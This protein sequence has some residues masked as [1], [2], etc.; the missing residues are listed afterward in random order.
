MAKIRVEEHK[1]IAKL[2]RQISIRKT[3][4]LRTGVH[5]LNRTTRNGTG[6][7]GFRKIADQREINYRGI[8][9]WSTE[10]E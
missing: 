9:R 7:I 10:S 2:V 8:L 3:R 4:L 6:I 5:S 1:G